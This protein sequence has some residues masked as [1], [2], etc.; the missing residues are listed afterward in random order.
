MSIVA[1]PD[2]GTPSREKRPRLRAY[3]VGHRDGELWAMEGNDPEAERSGIRMVSV[4]SCNVRQR[5]GIVPLGLHGS[6]WRGFEDGARDAQ[7][8]RRET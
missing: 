4:G 5:E 1:I 6:Y 8:E 2:G 3:E 7:G